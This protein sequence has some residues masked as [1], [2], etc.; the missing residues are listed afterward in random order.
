MRQKN[1]GR[2]PKNL[3]GCGMY[4]TVKSSSRKLETANTSKPKRTKPAIPMLANNFQI[5][6]N[7]KT[8]FH[9]KLYKKKNTQSE[10]SPTICGNQH[11]NNPYRQVSQIQSQTESLV[12][13]RI[14]PHRNRTATKTAL[15]RIASADGGDQIPTASMYSSTAKQNI[16]QNSFDNL[17]R[18]KSK[19]YLNE[20]LTIM[21]TTAI[22]IPR[23]R[24]KQPISQK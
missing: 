19:N 12:K 22:I 13:R 24:R 14:P 1:T 8:A 3:Q 16:E 5:P 20:S 2:P 10:S 23:Q 21:T 18:W 4:S 15:L 7:S 9:T 17:R 6:S 11:G